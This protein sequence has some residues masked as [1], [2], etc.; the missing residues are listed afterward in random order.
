MALLLVL[1]ITLVTFRVLVVNDDA[2]AQHDILSD[3]QR[4]SAIVA[5]DLSHHSLIISPKAESLPSRAFPCFI[6]CIPSRCF[7]CK[8]CTAKLE[9]RSP[10]DLKIA[11]TFAIFAALRSR[12]T[13]LIVRSQSRTNESGQCLHPLP[14]TLWNRFL[15][16]HGLKYR[17]HIL[18]FLVQCQSHDTL[19]NELLRRAMRS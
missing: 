15:A 14:L 12:N 13:N 19:P 9:F 10:I 11:G 2:S 1:Y 16:K 7:N 18:P 17:D 8:R 4:S 3:R 5:P 6:L